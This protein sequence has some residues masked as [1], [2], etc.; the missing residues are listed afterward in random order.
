[1]TPFRLLFFASFAGMALLSACESGITAFQ[2]E[3]TTKYSIEATGK[4]ARLDTAT[5]ASILCTGL[6]ERATDDGRF[7]VVANVKNRGHA[8]IEVRVRCVFKDASGFAIGDETAW[9][10][11]KLDDEMTEAVRFV[12][13]NKLARQYTVVVRS[14]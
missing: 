7:E 8:P 9:Q 13:S 12:A 1:M 14:P 10:L 11:L 2:Q 5:Q 3:E 4:F 6:Q